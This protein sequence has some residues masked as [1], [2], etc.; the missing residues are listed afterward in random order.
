MRSGITGK[1]SPI[2]MAS[3]NTVMNAKFAECFFGSAEM[4]E[5]VISSHMWLKERLIHVKRIG[6][7]RQVT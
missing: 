7:Q 1:I 4:S 3:R 5:L 6:S 2:P